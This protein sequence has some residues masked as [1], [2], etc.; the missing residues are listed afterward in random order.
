M[1]RTRDMLLFLVPNF[2]RRIARLAKPSFFSN[3]NVIQEILTSNEE[4]LRG[5]IFYKGEG[6]E[7]YSPTETG[8]IIENF[9][10]LPIWG[11]YH[12]STIAYKEERTWGYCLEKKL[13]DENILADKP[14]QSFEELLEW[15]I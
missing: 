11:A 13:F 2:V 14:T 3:Q 5:E 15:I 12:Y 7:G 4:M 9:G 8:Q 6:K 1:T 10:G